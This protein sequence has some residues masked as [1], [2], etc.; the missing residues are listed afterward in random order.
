MKSPRLAPPVT[1]A[2]MTVAMLVAPEPAAA[3]RIDVRTLLISGVPFQPF[4]DGDHA[5]PVAGPN[6]HFVAFDTTAAGVVADDANGVVRDVVLID[7]GSGE[8]RLVS[9]GPGGA[10]A[11]GPSSDAAVSADGVRVAFTSAASNLIA[12]DANG[13]T[14]VFY[15]DATGA[16]V[17]ASVT[18]DG[19]PGNRP[20]SNPDLSADGR[21]LVFESD[22]SDLVTGDSNGQRDVFLRD[23]QTGVTTRVSVAD[24][25]GQANAP[26]SN[27]AISAD[28]HVVAFESSASNLVTGDTNRTADV[29]VRDLN[30][31]TTDRVS[32]DSSGRQQDK[33]VAAPFRMVTDIDAQGQ[34]IVFD[35]EATNL[36]PVDLNERADVFL[37]DRRSL[38][39]RIVS[40]SSA[41]VQGN[42]DS[43]SPS[44]SPS[45]RYVTFQS[46]ASNL[47]AADS[48]GPD[49][50]IRDLQLRATTQVSVASDGAKRQAEMPGQPVLQRPTISDD[51]SLAAFISSAPLLAA[52]DNDRLTDVFVRRLAPPSTELLRRIGSV[53]RFGSDD[54]QVTRFLCRVDRRLPFPCGPAVSLI[55]GGRSMLVRATGPGLLPDAKGVTVRTRPDRLRPHVR[56]LRAPRTRSQRLVTGSAG[57]RGSGVDRVEVAAIYYVAGSSGRCRV[58]D[59]GVFRAATSCTERRFATLA[60]GRGQWR[61]TFPGRLPR[62]YVGVFARA[63][64]RAG[65]RSARATRI[66]LLRR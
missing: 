24:A 61:L 62:G 27:P 54:P 28:G 42:N 65:N 39:T 30:G 36:A 31:A 44:I 33:S 49:V 22:A 60:S 38:R 26:S 16:V 37:H 56:I 34:R 41:N 40:A 55:Q 23:L 8:R 13:V 4:T 45:G 10:P 17:P 53:A 43:V 9:A 66:I 57:D 47:A 46:F 21:L 15:R 48:T 11:D 50:F 29:F 5:N 32:I 6:G 25:G 2:L 58:L 3:T 20:S 1:A 7:A 14:D 51:G 12:E 35:S 63:V 52:G 64:D 19:R 59:N 18:P